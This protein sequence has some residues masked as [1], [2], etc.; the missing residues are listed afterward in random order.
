MS[1]M[2]EGL[3]TRIIRDPSVRLVGR[4]TIDEDALTEFLEDEGVASW[5]T[6]AEVAGG[7]LVGAAGRARRHRAGRDDRAV[8]G[9]PRS[10]GGGGPPP[11]RPPPGLAGEKRAGGPGCRRKKGS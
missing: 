10:R 4:L 3:A 6:D 7:E 1:I 2:E 8:R 5:M 11:W 9:S